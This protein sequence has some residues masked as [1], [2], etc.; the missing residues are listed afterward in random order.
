[1]KAM[2][3]S[4]TWTDSSQDITLQ[5][6]QSAGT[7]TM[8]LGKFDNSVVTKGESLGKLNHTTDT[9][10]GSAIILDTSKTVDGA[11]Y[12]TTLTFNFEQATK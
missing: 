2:D 7:A 3:A 4:T 1:M 6:D 8:H 12:K 5:G 10:N 9:N 11:S